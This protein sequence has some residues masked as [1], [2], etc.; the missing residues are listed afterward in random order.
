MEDLIPILFFLFLLLFVLTLIVIGFVVLMR[1]LIGLFSATH[2]KAQPN[3]LNLSTP[4]HGNHACRNCGHS[5]TIQ[6]KFCEVCGAQRLTLKQEEE[7]GE[8]DITLRQLEK[9]HWYSDESESDLENVKAR[10]ASARELILF[11][12]GRPTERAEPSPAVETPVSPVQSGTTAAPFITPAT[13]DEPATQPTPVFEEWSKDSDQRPIAAPIVKP[14]RKPWTDVLTAFMEESNVRWGEIIGGL[15][16]IGC[17]TALVISLWAQIS[18]VP[19]MKFLIFTTVTA[20]L[21][22]IGLYT[23]HHWKLPTTS[24]GILT[25][26]TLLVPLNFLAIA[27]VST[28]TTPGIAVIGSEIV[29]PVIFLCLV[30]FAGRTIASRWPH[31]LALGALGSSIGQLLVRHFAD[32]DIRPIVLVGLGAV[33]LIFYV[34]AIGWALKTA[35]SDGEIDETE[36]IEIFITLGA[37][38]FAAVLPFALLLYKAGPIEMSMMH[39][40]PLVTLAGM[41]MLASGM[42]LWR[43]VLDEKLGATRTAGASIAILGMAIALAGMV[44]G[45]PNPASIVLAALFN[46]LLFTAVAIALQES[47]SHVVAAACLAFGYSIAFHVFAGHVPWQNLREVSLLSVVGG[48]STGQ[49][50][51]VPFV[52]FILVHEWLSPRRNRDAS[53]YLVAA[54]GVAIVSLLFLIKFGIGIPGDPFYLSAIVALYAAGF[55]WIARR[56]RKV[57][58]TWAAT[59]LLFFASAQTCH[60]LL[61]LRFPWQASIL[62]LAITCSSGALLA[63]RFRTTEAERIFVWPMQTTALVAS[64]V[65]AALLFVDLLWFGCEP[66]LLFAVRAFILC[67]VL[68]GS[69]MLTRR[70]IFVTTSQIAFVAGTILLTKF[71]LQHFDWYGFQPNAWLHPWALQTQATVLAVLCLGWLT[72]RIVMRKQVA[73]AGALNDEHWFAKIILE[74]SLTFDRLLALGLVVAFTVVSVIASVNGIAKELTS[75]NRSPLQIDFAQ[76]PHALMFSAG[77]LLVLIVLLANMAGNLWERRHEAFAIGALLTLWTV[78]PL[79]AGRFESQFATA[80]AARWSV[81][82]FVLIGSLIFAASRTAYTGD[83]RRSGLSGFRVTSAIFLVITLAPL[84]LL[85]LS[86]VIDAVNYV[87]GRGPQSGM[88][89]AMSAAVL[90]GLPLILAILA[91]AIWAASKRSVLF[92]FAAGLFVNF[93]VTTVHIVSIAEL[94]GPMNRV[95]LVVSLQLNAIAAAS[96]TLVWLATRGWWLKTEDPARAELALLNWQRLFPIILNGFVLVPIAVHL[97]ALPPRVARATFAAG[98]F[99]GWVALW[100]TIVAAL[101]LSRFRF[102]PVKVTGV[103]LSL[104]SIALLLAFRTAQFGVANW[105]GL[106]VLLA[107]LILI[108]WAALLVRDLPRNQTAGRLVTALGL[109]FDDHWRQHSEVFSASVGAIVVMIAM[110]G[111]FSDP[112]GAWWSIGALLAMAMLAASLNWVTFRRAYLYAAGILFNVAVSIWLIKY[113]ANQINSLGAFVEVN[114]IALSLTGILWLCLEL[115]KRRVD[116]NGRVQTLVCFHHVAAVA[117]LAVV[118]ALTALRLQSDFLGLYQTFFPLLDTLTLASL[119]VLLI[120]VL[121]DGEAKYAVAGIYVLGLVIAATA[122]HHTPFAPR[123]MVWWLMIAAAVQTLV[124]TSLWH[125]RADI[126]A[127]ANR[128][129][130]PPRIDP[131]AT[132]LPWLLG[133]NSIVVT[134]ILAV[135]FAIEL[136]FPEWSLRSLA[137]LA[138]LVQCATFGLAAEGKRRMALQRT[139]VAML[140]VGIVFVSW[141]FLTPRVS[142]TWVNRSVIL[143]SVMFA[144]VGLFGLELSKITERKPDWAK[145]F[146]D[147]VPVMTLV[148][149]AALGFVLC[150]EIYFQIEFGAVPVSFPTRLTVAATL[151]ASIVICIFFALS[152]RHDPLSLSDKFR[153]SYVYTAEVMMVLLFMHIRLTM[154]WLFH[155][156][157]QRY[158]PLV[159]LSIAYAGVGIAEFFKRRNISVLA[160]PIERTGAFLPLLPVIGFWIAQSQVEYSTL[161]FV[162]GGL[163][164]LLSIL[165]KSFLFGLAAAVAGNGGLWYLLHE[166]S[167]YHFYQHP[168]VWVIPAALSVLIAAHLNRK[169]F[170]ETQISGI[171]YFCLI[172]I[173]VSSTADI[174]ING[175]ASSPW[176]PLVLGALSLAGVLSGM[177]FRVR[178]FLLL[179]STFLLLAIATMIKYASVNFGWT[180]LWYVAGIATGAVIIATF[181][182]LEKRRADVLRVVEGLKEWHA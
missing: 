79:L 98:A 172:T 55:F 27:A 160:K 177:V 149:I 20:A 96:V 130:M 158:W 171:R 162:V 142:G 59:A 118:T 1:W 103:G 15:L 174:F 80:S 21:F 157:F 43:R 153:G 57:A 155:G 127:L 46:F 132:E 134:V 168:Q 128:V 163:Y 119:L 173:Y 152:P 31:V 61:D 41:P 181:A 123:Q 180:W 87:P 140:L 108:V 6:L 133:F 85:T 101:A 165:R 147:C 120:A 11:P 9:L 164:G 146:R 114:L 167:N 48:V 49:S 136:S 81:A 70:S 50:L 5:L 22:G 72:L 24:R 16:I 104:I 36:S 32:A 69:L 19:V 176:L 33:P 44:L 56:T 28:N 141:S 47:R 93:A 75:A 3:P 139:A 154:P 179:G 109:A 64:V 110:R 51:A 39:V 76:H 107:T 115:R 88:F 151:A 2:T 116:A 113:Q 126:V 53:S 100:L 62:L 148:G 117:S 166:T 159:V 97:I 105:A 77:S 73:V 124:A 122:V 111:P 99:N 91:L 74:R 86:P 89:Q 14:P 60:S 90:Y 161:L 82:L 178:A 66:A 182:I 63:R 83:R 38:T 68:I 92:A 37:L 29:A 150:A 71:G 34:G 7:L 12:H 94:H 143:M 145:A 84:V 169:D 170:S 40:A 45:W 30:Y 102:K 18:R 4:P 156:F 35:F 26:A 67:A 52:A 25:I 137:A 58:F 121:W 129:K 10:I 17:S 135:A 23:E 175:V 131:S 106:H 125:V 95:A 54:C 8:L 42:L 78:C 138:V 144:F 65:A 13:F 112:L